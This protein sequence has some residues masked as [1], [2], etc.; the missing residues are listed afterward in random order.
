MNAPANIPIVW[1][2]RPFDGAVHKRILEVTPRM[3]TIAE[4]VATIP[5]HEMPIGFAEHGC[6]RVN[7]DE[8]PRGC[9]HLVRPKYV[10]GFGTVVSLHMPLRGG[11]ASGGGSGKSIIGTIASIAV[12]L[13]GAAVSG[14]LLAGLG[15]IF[16]GLTA[17]SLGATVAGAAVGIGGALA[18]AALIPPPTP[19]NASTAIA[20]TGTGAAAASSV[21]FTAASLSGNVLSPGASVP[22]AIG[23]MQLFP[24]LLCNPLIELVG[25]V[26]IGEAV[27][28]LA[29]PHALSGVTVGGVDV[30]S[31]TGVTVQLVEG[32]V[33][34]AIQGL[35]S[36]QSFTL[37]ANAQLIPHTLN[38]TTQIQLLDQSN[39]AADVPQPQA[40]VSRNSPDEIWITLQWGSG[41]VD[42]ANTALII[43]QAVRVQFRR[44]GSSTWINAPEVHFSQNAV[45]AFEK[46]IRLKWGSF[47]VAPS[48]P[49]INQAPVYA[50]KTVPG[51]DGTTAAPAT[52]GWTADGSFS[53]GAGN[54]LLSSAT[55]L[56]SN[57][58]NTELYADKVIFY[59]DP[60]AFPR[61]YY[62]V[63]VAQSCAYNNA[64]FVAASYKY[65]ATVFD[66]FNYTT[67]AGIFQLPVDP[68]SI[69]S[70]V[71]VTRVSSIWN[72]NPIQSTDFATVSIK[73]QG[74][75][76]DQLAVLCSGYVHDWDGS[77]W[78][79][80]TTTSNPAPHFRDVL[81]GALG[82]SPVPPALINDAE[83]VQWRSDCISKGYTCNAVIESNSYI[84]AL[85]LIA[86][87]GYANVR[88]N[89]KWGVYEDRDVSAEAPIQIFNPRNMANFNW[90][91]AFA[92]LPSGIRA[93]YVNAD[94]NYISDEIIVY[95]DP[96][97]EDADNLEQI[98][99]YGLVHAA[100]VI[101]RANYD[102]LN[103]QLRFTFYQG[104][105]S[106][107]SLVCQR[108]DLVGVQHDILI[109]QAGFSRIKDVLKLSGNVTGLDLDGS[110]PV[111]TTPGI[112]STAHLFTTA[113]LF[114]LG[115][116]TGVSIR[117][118]SGNG[119]LTKEI[120]A[121]SNG[122]NTA[123]SFVTPFAD[124]GADLDSD[125]LVSAGPFGQTFR[126]LLVHGVQPA[127]D[128][129]A[130]VVFVDEAPQ[131]WQ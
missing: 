104:D 10:A 7:G 62:E 11:G 28:G 23:T 120:T 67:S 80:F 72:E 40:F 119:I 87:S 49:S 115:Q 92:K 61:D 91:R 127:A 125:C 74:R 98:T 37:N 54:D 60:T 30:N 44:K 117:L 69:N 59:L 48:S 130:T 112:F 82:A 2:S 13:V 126:R 50:F 25:D 16:S 6:V 64:N 33:G 95:T 101:K 66:F 39:P 4:I 29:G 26:E 68:T 52:A 113:D 118:K 46:V 8:V 86:T 47:P 97:R 56:S 102:L 9:W 12:L 84:D 24:P 88:H 75:A 31:M 45:G 51:Q 63:Q 36:R 38:A 3:P 124:P 20:S 34:D 43:N 100:D 83:L 81:A 76:L 15:G 96:G 41:L 103:A 71:S 17:G 79:T 14:G 1:K 94:D 131:L 93:T 129:A 55:I 107:E 32:K 89:E 22:R 121:A 21:A 78:N 105:T 114:T 58:A 70:G 53:H 116:Q 27:F 123:I 42:G 35:V 77:G 73:V 85:T 19:A 99:Y 108:G 111:F 65:S 122:D 128:M 18:V 110:I 109:K 106:I 5:D 90:T 57:V